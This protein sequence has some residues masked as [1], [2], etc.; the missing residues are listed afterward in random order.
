MRLWLYSVGYNLI[1]SSSEPGIWHNLKFTTQFSGGMA[2]N[3]NEIWGAHNGINVQ[4][5]M[6]NFVLINVSEARDQ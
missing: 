4:Q 3:G 6:L 2:E 1:C 5:G